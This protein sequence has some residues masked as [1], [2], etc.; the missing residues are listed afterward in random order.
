MGQASDRD[1]EERLL[2]GFKWNN[3]KA[4]VENSDEVLDDVL[5]EDIDVFDLAPAIKGDGRDVWIADFPFQLTRN[6]ILDAKRQDDFCQTVLTRQS[7]KTDSAFYEDEY[8]LLRTLQPTI[9]DIDHTVLPETLRP[10]V[11]DLAHYSKL[12]GHLG[13]IRIYEH[14]RSTY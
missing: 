2:N 10:R 4:N 8:G 1:V 6:E 3:T 11:L 13:K 12:T 9:N 14:E 7:R 5:D